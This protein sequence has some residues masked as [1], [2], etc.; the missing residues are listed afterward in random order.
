MPYGMSMS[1]SELREKISEL[2]RQ[3]DPSYN[4]V[5]TIDRSFCSE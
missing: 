2:V 3:K 1:E 4:C 5:I